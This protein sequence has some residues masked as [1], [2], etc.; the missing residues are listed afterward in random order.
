MGIKDPEDKLPTEEE[1]KQWQTEIHMEAMKQLEEQKAQANI[2]EAGE[3]GYKAE[4]LR[5]GA[6]AKE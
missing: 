3:A 4:Q 6:Y 5:L 2:E 1:I